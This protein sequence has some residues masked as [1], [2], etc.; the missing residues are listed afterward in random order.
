MF[1]HIQPQI[2]SSLSSSYVGEPSSGPEEPSMTSTWTQEMREKFRSSAEDNDEDE[3][4]SV[5]GSDMSDN[6][7]EDD[8]EEVSED[9]EKTS[10]PV[11]HVPAGMGIECLPAGVVYEP[12]DNEGEDDGQDQEQEDEQ[13]EYEDEQDD[14]E[15]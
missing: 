13:N 10:M 2:V 14:D 5:G 9:D 1:R 4:S 3:N 7:E 12:E 8:D 6:D 15:I 11:M